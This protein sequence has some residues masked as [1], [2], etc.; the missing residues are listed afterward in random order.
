[1]ISG[2]IIG[3]GAQIGSDCII[4]DSFIAPNARIKAGSIILN[5]YLGF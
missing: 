2:S 3:E 5:N 1:V 4:T